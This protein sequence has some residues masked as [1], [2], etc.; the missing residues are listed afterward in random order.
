[1]TNVTISVEDVVGV[2]RPGKLCIQAVDLRTDGSGVT[3]LPN[4]HSVPIKS[5]G[6]AEVVGVRPGPAY[7]TI[8]VQ[9]YSREYMVTIPEAVE[10]DLG[11]LLYEQQDFPPAVI[12]QVAA[13]AQEA[14]ESML[15]A[16]QASQEAE[17]TAQSVLDLEAD[18]ESAALDAELAATQAQGYATTAS[19][20]AGEAATSAADA[21]N[22]AGVSESFATL[23]EADAISAGSAA[24]L[25]GDH[26]AAASASAGSALD[27]LGDAQD[28]AI[29]AVIAKNDTQDLLDGFDVTAVAVEGPAV[30]VT[31]T[32]DGHEY[33]LAFTLPKG[34]K[35]DKG[36]T[37]TVPQQQIDAAV[38]SVV[39]SAPEALDTLEELAA[40]LGDDPNFATTVSQQIGERAKTSDVQ[41]WLADKS[42]TGHKHV[43]TDITDA[44]ST[45]RGVITGTAQQGRDALS[46]P[47]LTEMQARPAMWVWDGQGTWTPPP[48]AVATDTV[49]NLDTSELHSVEDI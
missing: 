22:A 13:L 2:A 8:T 48:G 30:N 29:S 31:V 47:S 45:G 14:R 25:A 12:S 11:E 9:D 34:P 44:T 15:S 27:A 7:V 18:F 38:A 49:L 10:V 16:Q 26:A 24:G 6:T 46:V 20:K 37:G 43:A 42:D 17:A 3:I 28:A 36:D 1:M 32:K 39:G 35:G 4:M 40:A 41:T 5:D 23:T 33:E 19:T 21:L